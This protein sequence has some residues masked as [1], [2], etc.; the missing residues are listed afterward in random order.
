VR[1]LGGHDLIGV[2][3]RYLPAYPRPAIG[4]GAAYSSLPNSLGI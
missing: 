3:A 2:I 4:T 1:N